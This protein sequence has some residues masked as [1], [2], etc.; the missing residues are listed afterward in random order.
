VDQ[1]GNTTIKIKGVTNEGMKS[2]T[3]NSLERLLIQND[4]LELKQFKWFKKVIDGNI[5]IK[6][7]VYKLKVTSNKR[8]P[9]Y[10]NENG[11]NIFSS[12]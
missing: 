6:E 3:M 1:D 10:I 4:E 11:V 2:I 7:A 5:T 8:A 12:N 9:V